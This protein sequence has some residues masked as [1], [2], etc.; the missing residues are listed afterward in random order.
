MA[1]TG[2]TNGPYFFAGN[3]S[4]MNGHWNC[5]PRAFTNTAPSGYKALCTANLS[6]PTIADGST[7][8]DSKLYSETGSSQSITGLGFSPDLV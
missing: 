7:A 8:F 2:L 5:G 4:S 6:D 3:A 1:F